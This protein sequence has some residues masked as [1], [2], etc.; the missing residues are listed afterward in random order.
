VLVQHPTLGSAIFRTGDVSDGGVYLQKGEFELGVGDMVI[1][2][3]QDVPVEA[4]R[5]RMQVMRT[6]AGGYGLQFAD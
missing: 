1:V 3:I 6:D 5:M 4:P 2:Q